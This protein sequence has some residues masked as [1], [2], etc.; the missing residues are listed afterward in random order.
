M[1]TEGSRMWPAD[2]DDWIEN[3]CAFALG[4]TSAL[5]RAYPVARAHAD[6]LAGQAVEEIRDEAA[7]LRA[8]PGF[9]ADGRECAFWARARCRQ[10]AIARAVRQGRILPWFR[11]LPEPDF[12]LLWWCY[13][14]RLSLFDL[15]R[16]LRPEPAARPLTQQE[17]RQ[18]VRAA[19]GALQ[20]LLLEEW[21][22]DNYT[23]PE[24]E[25]LQALEA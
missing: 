18:R 7:L 6:A 25:Q 8:I 11:Q 12:R 14:D 20:A 17:A 9:F 16:L 22:G 23:F 24:P 10:G 15:G 4:A 1:D 5:L 19:F 13:V 3:A 2:A 21:P